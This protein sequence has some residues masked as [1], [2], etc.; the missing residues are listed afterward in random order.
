MEAKMQVPNGS[1]LPDM[2]LWGKLAFWLNCWCKAKW[3]VEKEELRDGE[4]T[5]ILIGDMMAH[6]GDWIVREKGGA[7]SVLRH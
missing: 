1:T 2:I 6:P 4:S 5:G 7:F 3:T